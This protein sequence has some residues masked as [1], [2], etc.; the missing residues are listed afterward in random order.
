MKN[1]N[2]VLPRV[3]KKLGRQLFEQNIE[4]VYYLKSSKQYIGY[5]R[6]FILE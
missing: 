5:I 4:S 1:W 3:M 2:L 6:N